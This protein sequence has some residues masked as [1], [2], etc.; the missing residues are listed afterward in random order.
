MTKTSYLKYVGE[1]VFVVVLT[2]M[3]LCV[4]MWSKT[5]SVDVM[6]GHTVSMRSQRHI[7]F[8]TNRDRLNPM[9]GG[10]TVSDL[11][12]NASF[13]TA[14]PVLVPKTRTRARHR[15]ALV[16]ATHDKGT[17]SMVQQ[18]SLT[19]TNDLPEGEPSELWERRKQFRR[20]YCALH[21]CDVVWDTEQYHMNRTMLLQIIGGRTER[22]PMPPYWNKAFALQKALPHYDYVVLLDADCVWT[23]FTVSIQDLVEQLSDDQVAL[24][25]EPAAIIVKNSHWGRRLVDLWVE[26]GTGDGCRYHKYPYNHMY[27]TINADMPWW[28]FAQTKI[29]GEYYNVTIPCLDP[30]AGPDTY[31]D[32]LMKLEKPLRDKHQAMWIAKCYDMTTDSNVWKPALMANET[33]VD[34]T[35]LLLQKLSLPQGLVFMLDLQY[36]LPHSAPITSSLARAVILHVKDYPEGAGTKYEIEKRFAEVVF[37]NRL[38]KTLDAM[39]AEVNKVYVDSRV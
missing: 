32:N 9:N 1:F 31:V 15:I 2:V 39:E 10:A 27:Q 29:L 20:L 3:L 8:A 7:S 21:H 30:C 33:W 26:Y 5:T 28:W 4:G 11:S 22:G 17:M 37:K 35:A 12:L 25:G 24:R 6:K 23:D 38:N 13:N 19:K 14:I 18:R 16:S 34:P 36:G